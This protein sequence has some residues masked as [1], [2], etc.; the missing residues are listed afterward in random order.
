MDFESSRGFYPHVDVHDQ[1]AFYSVFS[2]VPYYLSRINPEKS[3]RE[4]IITSILQNGSVLFNEVEFLLKQELREVSVYNTVITSV[5]LF[6][7]LW[8]LLLFTIQ[9]IKQKIS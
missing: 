1:V 3:L 8:I 9:M 4:N 6:C 5:L 7:S 2:G